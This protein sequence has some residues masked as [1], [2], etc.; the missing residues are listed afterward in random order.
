MVEVA[1]KVLAGEVTADYIV[2]T[3]W[4]D[5]SSV[6]DMLSLGVGQG[7]VAPREREQLGRSDVGVIMLRKI[8]MRELRALE[9]GQPLKEWKHLQG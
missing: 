3:R 7:V 2:K 9:Q 6:Q 1:R 4:W 8:Y 5:G